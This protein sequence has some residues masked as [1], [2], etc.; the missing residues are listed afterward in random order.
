MGKL[1][2]V[3]CFDCTGRSARTAQ[4]RVYFPRLESI[5]LSLPHFLSLPFSARSQLIIYYLVAL[6][7]ERQLL[8]LVNI[9]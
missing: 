7:T 8:L 3:Y 5:S 1:T 2:S 4:Q 6:S 9:C